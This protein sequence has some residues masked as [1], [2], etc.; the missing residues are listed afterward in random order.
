MVVSFT[1][2]ANTTAPYTFISSELPG[3]FSDNSITLRPAQKIA[4]EFYADDLE[5]TETK[6]LAS[7]RVYTMNNVL[8]Q[9]LV[10]RANHLLS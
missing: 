9:Y 6:F 8:P 1:I 2:E 4:L 3:T 10:P 7:C 5:I